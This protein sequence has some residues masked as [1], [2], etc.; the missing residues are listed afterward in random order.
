MFLFHS[1]ALYVPAYE[2]RKRKSWKAQGFQNGHCLSTEAS[3]YL[4]SGQRFFPC[5]DYSTAKCCAIYFWQLVLVTVF[6]E[7][8]Q[9]EWISVL[10][11][12]LP[13][14]EQQG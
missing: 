4:V 12:K 6:K 11:Q 3:C 5:I 1:S 14:L 2:V 10:I 8:I 7:R 9:A 13:F